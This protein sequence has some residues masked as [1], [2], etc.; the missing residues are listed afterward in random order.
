MSKVNVRI[1]TVLRVHVGGESQV[2]AE[3]A[4]VGEVVNGLVATHPG[5]KTN[6]LDDEGSVRK[7]VNIYV[8][9]EDIRFLDRLETP[10]T[11]GDEVA[12]LPAVA[13]G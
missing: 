5:L 4:T 3:G 10:V 7:F 12:V 1:P 6:L 11:D 9:D 2:A 13:G 8:N